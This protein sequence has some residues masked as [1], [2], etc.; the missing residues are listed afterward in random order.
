MKD[1][2]IQS[3]IFGEVLFDIF[4]DGK[5]MLGGAPFNVASHLQ[6]F[7]QRP[8][9]VSRVGDDADG[10]R[11]ISAMKGR[12]MDMSFLQIDSIHATGRVEVRIDAGE[13]DYD[14]VKNRAYDFIAP[15][16]LPETDNTL[17]YHGSLALRN[18][19]SRETLARLKN[20]HNGIIFTDVNL[21]DPWWNVQ[22]VDRLVDDADWVK[23]NEDELNML[24]EEGT[25]DND[26]ISHF[27]SL[28]NLTGVIVTRGSRGATALTATGEIAE[29]TP[30]KEIR[31]VDTVGAGDAFASVL[32]LGICH[33]WSLSLMMERAQS[34]A[35]HIVGR[36][37]AT[38]DDMS[39]YQPMIQSWNL[40]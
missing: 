33:G 17:L 29:A 16:G 21:R 12:G 27:L 26:K 39:F 37:G 10:H 18:A 1:N 3:I 20:Q 9:F 32:I 11:I 28:H 24:T 25:Y 5:S 6:A 36:Q 8:G 23:L 22:L 31:V 19:E 30:D 38:V 14:I 34:F 4:P 15:E 13:P 7:G 35:S 2:N 40:M